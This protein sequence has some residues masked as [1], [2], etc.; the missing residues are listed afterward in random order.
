MS[1][2]TQSATAPVPLSRSVPMLHDSKRGDFPV[3]GS[4]VG[5]RGFPWAEANL[6]VMPQ[7]ARQDDKRG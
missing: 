4:L 6:S 3:L 1:P 2:I 7:I 5:V